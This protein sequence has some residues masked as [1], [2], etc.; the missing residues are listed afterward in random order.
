MAPAAKRI[1]NI[2]WNRFCSLSN[3][4]AGGRRVAQ[5]YNSITGIMYLSNLQVWVAKDLKSEKI[6]PQSLISIYDSCKYLFIGFL[7]QLHPLVM[8]SHKNLWCNNEFKVV[9]GW[10]ILSLFGWRKAN[11]LSWSVMP[12]KNQGKSA[13]RRQQHMQVYTNNNNEFLSRP[14]SAFKLCPAQK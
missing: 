3:R 4:R 14:S 8:V 13:T 7:S 11:L 12:L 9:G 10:W 1:N 6:L 5:H 2:C